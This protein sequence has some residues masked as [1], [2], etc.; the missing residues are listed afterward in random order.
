MLVGKVS[1]NFLCSEG[2]AKF[3]LCTKY[4]TDAKNQ[5]E[6]Q[7]SAENIYSRIIQYFDGDCK[8]FALKRLAYIFIQ[9]IISVLHDV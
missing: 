2:K 5:L 9:F 7:G 1:G 4:S 8:T 6:F 3:H